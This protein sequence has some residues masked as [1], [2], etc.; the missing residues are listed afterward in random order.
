MVSFSDNMGLVLEGGGMRGVFTSGVLDYM[1]DCGMRFPYCVAVSAGACNGLSFKSRQ[2]GRARRSNIDLLEQYRYI[3]M[4][5]FLT[6]HSIFDLK[7]MFDDLPNKILPFDYDACFSDPMHYEMVTTNCQTGEACYLLENADRKRL[8]DICRA[9]SSLPYVC[10]IV[11]V[12]N[13]PMLDGGIADS[14]PIERA[15]SQG[16]ERNVVVLTRNRGYRKKNKNLFLSKFIYH[17]YPR[18]Q[19]TL[20]KRFII[21]NQQLELIERLEAEEK[22]VVIRP[23]KPIEVNRLEKDTSKLTALYEEGYECA[24]RVLRL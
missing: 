16:F 8:L 24:K 11:N 12:D 7:M 2:R 1:M 6:Q 9:S 10:P 18:L 4:R 15:I 21:Y 5:H 17:K 13:V 20:K 23:V 3:G 14:I 22:V 19:A